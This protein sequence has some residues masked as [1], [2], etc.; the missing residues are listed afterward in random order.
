MSKLDLSLNHLLVTLPN[1]DDLNSNRVSF[2]TPQ[3]NS[4]M[5][6]W[7][8]KD[9]EGALK[10]FADTVFVMWPEPVATAN[11]ADDDDDD[12]DNDDDGMDEEEDGT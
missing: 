5:K 4:S 12:D 3:G 10:D 11:N 2:K 7:K 8:G 1:Q 9:L 6:I